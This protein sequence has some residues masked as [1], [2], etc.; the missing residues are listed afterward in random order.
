MSD[1]A[2]SSERKNRTHLSRVRL[3]ARSSLP[4]SS[5][6]HCDLTFFCLLQLHRFDIFEIIRARL[7][8]TAT[9]PSR[10]P[11]A[12]RNERLLHFALSSASYMPSWRPSTAASPL[13]PFSG[14]ATLRA[15][16][17]SQPAVRL[18]IGRLHSNLALVPFVPGVGS[19][20]QRPS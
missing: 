18:P 1:S 13:C 12:R 15:L 8:C 11:V 9:S 4:L 2:F 3:L 20:I 6:R 10:R 17:H 16:H 7:P 14:A 19:P 5:R